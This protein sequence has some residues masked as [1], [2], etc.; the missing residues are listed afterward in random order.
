MSNLEL[1]I[2]M[3]LEQGS[4]PSTISAVLEVPV[5]W[6]YEVSDSLNEHEPEDYCPFKTINS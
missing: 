5:S 2:E 3:M 6:V 4:H 1:E